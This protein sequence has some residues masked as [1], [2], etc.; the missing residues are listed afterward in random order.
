MLKSPLRSTQS[1]LSVR[2]ISLRLCHADPDSVISWHL[3]VMLGQHLSQLP[4]LPARQSA[5]C[6][7][8]HLV[9]VAPSHVWKLGQA[10]HSLLRTYLVSAHLVAAAPSQ[11]EPSGQSLH[12]LSEMY[13]VAAHSVRTSLPWSSFPFFSVSPPGREKVSVPASPYE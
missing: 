2:V 5:R 9:A 7:A 3:P 1:S 12:L 11:V 4:S 10:W 8:P 13:S 6:S